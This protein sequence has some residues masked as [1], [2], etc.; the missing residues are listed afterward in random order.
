MGI[1]YQ[2]T[3]STGLTNPSLAA[4]TAV[5]TT[6]VLGPLG[7]GSA[8]ISISGYINLTAG[9]GTTQ[10]AVRVRQ[11]AGTGGV[12]IG[13]SNFDTLAAGNTEAIPF[14]AT[15]VTNYLEGL[16]GGQYTITVQQTGGTA[17]GTANSIDVEV[18]V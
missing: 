6:P 15:D 5:F 3:Q 12:Q 8:A 18:M 4:E 9:T 13:P 10:V 1:L 17:N 16:N 2:T 14:G 11:G 7:A